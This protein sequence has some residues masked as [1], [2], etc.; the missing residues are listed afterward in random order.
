[1]LRVA[2]RPADRRAVLAWNIGDD[3]SPW[4]SPLRRSLLDHSD[5]VAQEGP[6]SISLPWW[7]FLSARRDVND[8][9]RGFSLRRGIDYE[10]D[11]SAEGLLLTSRR[12]DVSYDQAREEPEIAAAFL[13]EKLAA[14]GFVRQLTRFQLRN[15]GRIASL[16]AGA[17]FSVP[18]AGKTTEALASYF[19]RSTIDDRLLVISPKNAFGAWDEQ[20][21]DC[22]PTIDDRFVRLRGGKEKIAKLLDDNPRFMLITYQQLPRVRELIA[23]HITRHKT[24]IFLDE[25]HRIKSGAERQTPQAVLSI[26]HLPVGKLIMSGTPMPQSRQDLIP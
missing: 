23:S 21:T 19:Y 10:I 20:L 3:S 14:S 4:L 22:V 9:I 7:T 26:A 17:T 16:P 15:V 25:S 12:N 8:I 11:S 18:G 6:H 13:L 5:E 24:H 1:M 2:Y